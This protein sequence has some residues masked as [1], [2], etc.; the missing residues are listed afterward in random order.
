MA[1]QDQRAFRLAA[2]ILGIALVLGWVVPRVAT[3]PAARDQQPF[4]VDLDAEIP[5]TLGGAVSRPIAVTDGV[6]DRLA[7]AGFLFRAYTQA[8]EPPVWLWV[9]YYEN[10]RDATVHSP[11]GCYSGFGWAVAGVPEAAGSGDALGWDARWLQIKRQREKRLVLYWY[12]TAYGAVGSELQRNLLRLRGRV[13]GGTQLMFVRI[14]TPDDGRGDAQQRLTAIARHV[15]PH[16]RAP[17]DAAASA[18]SG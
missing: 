14:S 7:A 11:V 2:G 9:G 17:M 4:P 6:A 18:D 8:G 13:G 16:L 15:R 3:A 1:T 12:E 5:V 10:Q